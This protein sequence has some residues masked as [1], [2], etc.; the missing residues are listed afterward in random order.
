SKRIRK[1][2]LICGELSEDIRR[3]LG[4]KR[5]NALI[6]SPAHSVR[7][8]GFLAELGWGRWQD[9]QVDDASTLAPIYAHSGDPIPA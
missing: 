5:K 6:V 2:T 3:L 7:R 4:R 9:G 1:P 8:P